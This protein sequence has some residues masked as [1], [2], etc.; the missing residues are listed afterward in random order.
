MS[1]TLP[2]STPADT[3]ASRDTLLLRLLTP[4]P[5][6]EVTG[7]NDPERAQVEA[8][9]TE[10]FQS[11]WQARV[12]HFLPRLLSMHCMGSCSAVAGIRPASSGPLFL[13]TYLDQPV[14]QILAGAAQQTVLR[15]DVV[16][17]GNLV[18]SQRGASHILFLIMTATLHR[19]GYKWLVFTATRPLRNNLLKLGFPMLTL[20]SATPERLS[21]SE[22]EEWGTYYQSE[23][24][25]MAGSLDAAMQLIAERP[26]LRRVLRLYRYRINYLA[27]ALRGS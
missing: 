17:I 12:T 27:E 5:T 20:A 25:V 26:L 18:A 16:E 14:E 11:A 23:P 7:P 15:K 2:A 6:F 1:L 9:V 8:S 3:A 4:G 24:L 21:E 10:K 19:A 22:R 13:E